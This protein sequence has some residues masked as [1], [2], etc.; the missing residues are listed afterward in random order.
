VVTDVKRL[1]YMATWHKLVMLY[2]DVSG[3]RDSE[4]L[5]ELFWL[6]LQEPEI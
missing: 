3:V 5:R 4:I 1:Q 6:Q 2:D